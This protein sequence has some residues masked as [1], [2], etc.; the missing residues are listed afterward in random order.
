MTT[1]LTDP[2]STPVPFEDI[3]DDLERLAREHLLYYRVQ[4]GNL[5]L[6]HFWDDDPAAFSS[7]DRTKSAR[8]E[9][10]F[11]KCSDELTR[12]GLSM[13]Q[14][15]DSVRAAIVVRR[16]PAEVAQRLFL[17]QVLELT[18]LADPTARVQVAKAALTYDWSVRQLRD[19]V[20]ATRLGQ[21]LEETTATP[22]PSPV[23][24]AE[25]P[26]AVG[27]MVT[28]AEKLVAEVDHWSELWGQL[29]ARRMRKPQR[30]RLEAAVEALEARV[31]ALR[32][33]LRR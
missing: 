10:F 15:R 13:R 19:A 9:L 14:A 32:E 30:E 17:S 7:R 12:Y 31:A 23:V 21:P 33:T 22:T 5:L 27:R 20:T 25:R 26:P 6:R 1:S 3:L 8:F 18:R 4:V 28:R 16:L 29:D 11:D 24:A 2:S